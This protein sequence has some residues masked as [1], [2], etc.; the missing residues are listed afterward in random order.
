MEIQEDKEESSHRELLDSAA[1]VAQGEDADVD[2]AADQDCDQSKE[3]SEG[4][5][6]SPDPLQSKK[7]ESE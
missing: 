1:K 2:K 4:G 6:G 7:M 5:R 3:V